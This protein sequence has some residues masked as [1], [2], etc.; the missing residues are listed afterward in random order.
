MQ[1]T[2]MQLANRAWRKATRELGWHTGWRGSKK[3][4]KSFCH[5]NAHTTVTDGGEFFDNQESADE[6]VAVELSY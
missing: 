6:S 1:K 3:E 4:W 5:S 2:Q